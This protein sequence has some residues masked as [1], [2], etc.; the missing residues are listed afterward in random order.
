MRRKVHLELPGELDCGVCIFE[1][2]GAAGN[3]GRKHPAEFARVRSAQRGRRVSCGVPCYF[4]P[5]EGLLDGWAQEGA[6]RTRGRT[7]NREAVRPASF[8]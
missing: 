8:L 1:L 3:R 4:R 6:A 2:A 7:C 5:R